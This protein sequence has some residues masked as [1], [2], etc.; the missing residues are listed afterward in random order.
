MALAAEGLLEAHGELLHDAVLPLALEVDQ[1]LRAEPVLVPEAVG[2]QHGALEVPVQEDLGARRAVLRRCLQRVEPPADVLADGGGVDREDGVAGCV[3]QHLRRLVR[4][5]HDV[6]RVR[7]PAPQ[8]RRHGVPHVL[9]HLLL[10]GPV[11][12]VVKGHELRDLGAVQR[13]CERGSLL[14]VREAPRV[15]VVAAAAP[16]LDHG[17]VDHEAHV[18]LLVEARPAL[19]VAVGARV[20]LEGAQE[21][22][23]AAAVLGELLRAAHAD[24]RAR[25]EEPEVL[26][27]VG[28]AARLDQLLVTAPGGSDG[29]VGERQAH[30]GPPAAH[31][32]GALAEDVGLVAVAHGRRE[33]AERAGAEGHGSGVWGAGVVESFPLPVR[34]RSGRIGLA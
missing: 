34:K 20:R 1:G 4:E 23:R 30:G 33:D 2:Q 13:H 17:Q 19:R 12:R 5:G 32:D 28:H 29:A 26:A 27:D 31:V 8:E 7:G 25:V 16:V 10:V 24:L 9:V 18:G 11:A 15:V 14:V 6:L 3:D 22:L 21:P